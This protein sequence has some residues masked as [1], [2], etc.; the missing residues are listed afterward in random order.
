[1]YTNIFIC[2]TLTEFMVISLCARSYAKRIFPLNSNIVF[3]TKK[4]EKEGDFREEEEKEEF[5]K[6]RGNTEKK[7]ED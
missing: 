5:L 2:I 4:V 3:L 6:K 1:M 7:G